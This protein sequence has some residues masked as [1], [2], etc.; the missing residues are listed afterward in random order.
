[1][2]V[3]RL[4][5]K[6][7]TVYCHVVQSFIDSKW[8]L[9]CVYAAA[10][11]S[12]CDCCLHQCRAV[13]YKSRS[14]HS[15]QCFHLENAKHLLFVPSHAEIATREA[16]P[17]RACDIVTKNAL[18]LHPTPQCRQI[19][20]MWKQW[21]VSWCWMRLFRWQSAF[22]SENASG[23]FPDD[24]TDLGKW[25]RNADIDKFVFYFSKLRSASHPK[26]DLCPLK[27]FYE[28]FKF[29]YLGI[30]CS[31]LVI[32][33]IL[34]SLFKIHCMISACTEPLFAWCFWAAFFLLTFSN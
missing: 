7:E 19:P 6:G 27:F 11:P 16:S 10:F 9:L 31:R 8:S 1:M 5:V 28:N 21:T 13:R 24:I 2:I 17:T 23:C 4:L 25:I 3:W 12:L 18:V 30:A 22:C 29:F 33:T 26:G 20:C 32:H 15:P 34:L 14:F